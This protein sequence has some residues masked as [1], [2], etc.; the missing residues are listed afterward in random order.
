[1]AP[2]MA[3]EAYR[4][5]SEHCHGMRYR[6]TSGWFHRP[7]RRQL[8]ETRR[9]QTCT[10]RAARHRT[11][12]H[13]SGDAEAARNRPQNTDA[14]SLARQEKR[15]AERKRGADRCW[16]AAPRRLEFPV[17][18]QRAGIAS[19][20]LRS[21]HACEKCHSFNSMPF[22]PFDSH[23]TR[24]RHAR[25]GQRAVSRQQ[26]KP[27][28]KASEATRARQQA[29]SRTGTEGG[30]VRRRLWADIGSWLSLCCP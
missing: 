13:D 28:R 29:A 19:G 21:H 24:W 20:A 6:D 25:R 7:P 22:I 16:D 26:T 27:T 4:P 9:R 11:A 30:R 1:M 15:R 10:A 3:V 12:R 23:A 18:A 17:R 5:Q 14:E 2:T 8:R